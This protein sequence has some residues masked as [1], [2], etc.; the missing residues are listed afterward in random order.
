MSFMSEN[1][2]RIKSIRPV[3][4]GMD[5]LH[6]LLFSKNHLDISLTRGN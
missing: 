6:L 1:E 2:L 4:D 3:V 5:S